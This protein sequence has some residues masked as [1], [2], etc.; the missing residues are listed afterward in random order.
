MR[1]L[2]PRVFGRVVELACCLLAA[3]GAAS[4]L[5]CQSSTDKARSEM[6]PVYRSARSLGE[7]VKAGA[8]LDDFNR[9]R[10]N[11]ATEISIVKDRMQSEPTT[12]KLLQPYFSA[13]GNAL[14]AYSLVGD[15]LK[16]NSEMDAC[17]GT[18]AASNLQTAVDAL[19]RI[20]KCLDSTGGTSRLDELDQR[21]EQLKTQCGPQVIYHVDCI[22]KNAE[23]K[24]AAADA[25]L[26]RR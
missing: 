10:G 4:L 14:D 22:V 6:E 15:V 24:A 21:S 9:L 1:T 13:Y 23:A 25:L 11:F 8:R 20:A 16:Y 26:L 18:S 5:N 2:Q 17:A 12:A 19:K 3:L 7:Q